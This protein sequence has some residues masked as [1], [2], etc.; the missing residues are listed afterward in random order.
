MAGFNFVNFSTYFAV[1]IK[2][3][4]IYAF[5][6]DFLIFEDIQNQVK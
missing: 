2:Q 4:N 5:L 1:A 6:L 3:T